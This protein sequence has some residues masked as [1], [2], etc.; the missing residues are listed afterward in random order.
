MGAGGNLS[1]SSSSAAVA[2]AYTESEG[3]DSF[4]H[5]RR[6]DPSES[7][8]P[9]FCWIIGKAIRH[10]TRDHARA[11][12]STQNGPCVAH[13]E[14]NLC[15]PILHRIP[16]LQIRFSMSIR[17]HLPGLQEVGSIMM[18]QEQHAACCHLLNIY[19][20]PGWTV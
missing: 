12:T 6:P 9:S 7:L 16:K 18:V 5:N 4:A 3:I 10:L 20:A 2:A 11:T 1:A 15:R 8:A 13:S 19:K 17:G 14:R